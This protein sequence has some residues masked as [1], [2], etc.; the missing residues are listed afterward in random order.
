MSSENE[1][2]FAADLKVIAERLAISEQVKR[3]DTAEEKGAWTLAHNFLDLAESFTTFLTGQL[4]ALKDDSLR[5]EEVNALLF[6]IGEE[7]RH[8]LY[9]LRDSKF[10]AYL[11]D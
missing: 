6:E 2:K 1:R 4:P 7:F 9:H 10:Y 8:I 5:A 3:Y 11:R